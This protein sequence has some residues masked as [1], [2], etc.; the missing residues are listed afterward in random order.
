MKKITL[1]VG[2]ND[3]DTKT[4]KIDTVEAVKIV[5]N[6]IYTMMD[7]GTIYNATGIY[8]HE[9][10]DI[11]I[12]NTLRIELIEC[13]DK[14]LGRLIETLKSVLNQETIIKQTELI[15]SELV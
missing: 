4:Q 8:K 6:L 11:V 1:Y 14:S 12:E 2:L 5:S 7:G 15:N 9:N 3:K 13:D 10:G